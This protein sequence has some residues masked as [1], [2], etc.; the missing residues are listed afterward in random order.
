LGLR[1]STEASPDE[2][3]DRTMAEAKREREMYMI[4]HSSE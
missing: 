2:D 3:N 4:E 1:C